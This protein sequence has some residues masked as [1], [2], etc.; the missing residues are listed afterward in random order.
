MIEGA[1][2]E[3]GYGHNVSGDSMGTCRA[4]LMQAACLGSFRVSAPGI[5]Q[6][7][8]HPPSTLGCCLPAPETA[9]DTRHGGQVETDLSRRTCPDGD[10]RC[11][12]FFSVI[13]STNVKSP[14]HG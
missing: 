9:H 3:R 1:L 10:M 4:P 14:K 11:C 13:E 8:V 7:E 12:D 6:V 2:H 5:I